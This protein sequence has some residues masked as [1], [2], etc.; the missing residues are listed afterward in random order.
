[1][2][3]LK[4]WMCFSGKMTYKFWLFTKTNPPILSLKIDLT[5]HSICCYWKYNF[6]FL[7]GFWNE[8]IN[9]KRFQFMAISKSICDNSDKWWRQLES[10]VKG[11]GKQKV[12]K[13]INN[14]C[15]KDGDYHSLESGGSGTEDDWFFYVL[16]SI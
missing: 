14:F 8:K 10:R 4:K 15:W 13:I 9:I 3:L 1:M 5:F 11:K 12:R 7:R 6:S 2:V 16:K